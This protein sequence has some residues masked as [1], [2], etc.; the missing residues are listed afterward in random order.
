MCKEFRSSSTSSDSLLSLIRIISIDSLLFFIYIFFSRSFILNTRV[1]HPGWYELFFSLIV[2]CCGFDFVNLTP[3][4]AG[5]LNL[6]F[7]EALLITRISADLLPDEA[8]PPVPWN[9][10]TRIPVCLAN[11]RFR[12]AESFADY[13]IEG[14]DALIIYFRDIYLFTRREVL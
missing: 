9:K 11:E 2:L 6:I 5:E 1:T 14:D 8:A 7:P 3:K 10:R 13:D 12:I 4:D